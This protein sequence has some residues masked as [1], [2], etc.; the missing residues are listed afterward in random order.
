MFRPVVMPFE[1]VPRANT[2]VS[3]G[4]RVTEAPGMAVNILFGVVEL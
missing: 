3:G 4:A 1:M 2:P